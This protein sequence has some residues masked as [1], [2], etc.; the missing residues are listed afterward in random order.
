MKVSPQFLMVALIFSC[1]PA[2]AL[3]EAAIPADLPDEYHQCHSLLNSEPLN[4]LSEFVD[5]GRGAMIS[6][7]DLGKRLIGVSCTDE[8]II[9]YMENH[10]FEHGQTL[11]W[12]E[13]KEHVLLGQYNKVMSFSTR[14]KKNWLHRKLYGAFAVGSRFMMRNDTIVRISGAAHK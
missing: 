1:A 4:T 10:G 12:P 8:Q 3:E 13:P 5:V 2:N 7:D 14:S 6:D 9:D 11:S